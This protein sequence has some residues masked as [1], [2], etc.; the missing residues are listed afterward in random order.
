MTSSRAWSAWPGREE[1]AEVLKLVKPRHF[2]PVHGE[3][4]F[5]CAHA[6]LALDLGFRNTS[7]IRNGQMLGVSPLRNGR[8]LSTGSATVLPRAALPEPGP[9]PLHPDSWAA[10]TW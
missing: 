8:T 2:L 10:P 3:Y 4:A 6:Q 7:V 5:L 9:V 1:L